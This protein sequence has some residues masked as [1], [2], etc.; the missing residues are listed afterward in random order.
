VAL[1]TLGH[2]AS[3]CLR[4]RAA[5]WAITSSGLCESAFS[6]TRLAYDM[7]RLYDRSRNRPISFE[8]AQGQPL[9]RTRLSRYS[10]PFA[11]ARDPKAKLA[12]CVDQQ[13][14]SHRA[15]STR[16]GRCAKMPRDVHQHLQRSSA[17]RCS[18]MRST[19]IPI[20]GSSTFSQVGQEYQLMERV[21]GALVAR[22]HRP[23]HPPSS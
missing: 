17:D 6:I 13:G 4:T 12:Q 20:P 16:R 9:S 15:R 19:T 7:D 14:A 8:T 2:K 10:A 3:S 21:P 23:R 5:G 1:R 22:Q 11:L 18:R